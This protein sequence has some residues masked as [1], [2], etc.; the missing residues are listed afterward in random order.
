MNTQAKLLNRRTEPDHP[1]T[2]ECDRCGQ[3]RPANPE[4]FVVTAS[5]FSDATADYE[6]ALLCGECW[7][8]VHDELRRC[9]A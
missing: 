5:D 6:R 7:R 4:R 1:R 8:H 9:F 3:D 2:A